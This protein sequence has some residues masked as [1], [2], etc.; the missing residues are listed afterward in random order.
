MVPE[1]KK[2]LFD[3]RESIDP[4]AAARILRVASKKQN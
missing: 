1:I 4:H 3:I 2:Y